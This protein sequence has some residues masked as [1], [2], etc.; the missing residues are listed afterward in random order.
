MIYLLRVVLVAAVLLCVQGTAGADD[1]YAHF[2]AI[3]AY[4]GLPQIE[5]SAHLQAAAQRRVDTLAEK[6]WTKKKKVR[7]LFRRKKNRGKPN[8]QLGQKAG[9]REGVGYRSGNDPLGKRFRA[10]NMN[11]T[12]YHYCGA[13]TSVRGGS[14]YYCLIWGN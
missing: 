1:A 12:G 8:H 14:T 13:A 2:S 5:Q 9:S 11:R 6:G 7:G 4:T 3:R 10:C